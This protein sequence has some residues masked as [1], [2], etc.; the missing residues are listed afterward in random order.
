MTSKVSFIV[1]LEEFAS[2]MLEDM[3][4]KNVCNLCAIRGGACVFFAWG[5][6]CESCEERF[7]ADC[8]YR[9]INTWEEF[10]RSDDFNPNAGKFGRDIVPTDRLFDYILPAFY[11][12]GNRQ[13]NRGYG[14]NVQP[15]AAAQSFANQATP[16][17]T[18]NMEELGRTV[19]NAM[20]MGNPPQDQYVQTR[21]GARTVA[22]AN[23]PEQD[24]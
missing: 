4:P 22:F 13:F 18:V 9:N 11:L 7:S 17:A 3:K 1:R 24:F 16:V 14:Q 8:C 2:Y 20:R 12:N 15:S 10:R 6:S 21:S 23:P 5:R 19:F